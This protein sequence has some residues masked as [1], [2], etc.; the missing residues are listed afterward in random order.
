MADAVA[1]VLPMRDKVIWASLLC[2]LI[3]CIAFVVQQIFAEE[4]RVFLAQMTELLHPWA[5][6]AAVLVVMDGMLRLWFQII[7]K[8]AERAIRQS[9]NTLRYF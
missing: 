5:K 7:G 4:I 8:D 3:Y 6:I 9:F 2:L 1:V